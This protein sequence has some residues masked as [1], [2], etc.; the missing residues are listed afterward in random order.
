MSTQ[1]RASVS[2]RQQSQP[3]TFKLSAKAL[4]ALPVR[5]FALPAASWFSHRSTVSPLQPPSRD[6]EITPVFSV[7]LEDVLNRQ[8]LPPLGL[9]DFE[10]WLLYVEKCPENL[11]F[12]LWL[13]EYTTKYNQWSSAYK[14]RRPSISPSSTA[15]RVAFP[16]AESSASLAL[17]YTRAKQTFFTPKSPYEL[18]ISSDILSP[19]HTSNF[20]SP[21]PDPA[22]FAEVAVETQHR[23]KESLERMVVAAYTNVGNDRALCGMIGGTGIMLLGSIPPLLVAFLDGRSR[24]LRLLAIPGLWIGLTVVLASLHGVCMMV[25]VFGDLRQLRK[26]ELSRPPISR[27]QPLINPRLRPPT[28]SSYTAPEP[29]VLPVAQPPISPPPRAL[30]VAIPQ[31]AVLRDP[32]RARSVSASS[33]SSGGSTST[34]SSSGSSSAGQSSTRHALTI[35]I[36]PAYFDEAHLEGPATGYA[37]PPYAHAAYAFP[38]L[39]DARAAGDGADSSVDEFTPTASFIHP[40]DPLCDEDFDAAREMTPAE[41][42]AIGPFDF[43]LL[44]KRGY[45]FPARSRASSDAADAQR[46]GTGVLAGLARAQAAC[47][48]PRAE[49]AASPPSSR[50]VSA[51]DMAA[52]FR[53]VNAV[54]AFASPF[55]RVLNPVVTRAQWEIVVRSALLAGLAC[56]GFVGALLAV[57]ARH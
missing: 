49:K 6:R 37:H 57:P 42:Q 18:K 2:Q 51:R 45:R 9:K 19:F 16:A 33:S 23:L 36:S 4:L 50:P 56:W 48:Q 15:Y 8:H 30:R 35:E 52:Q 31:R 11:Y 54:P 32:P 40:Y 13:K 46:T 17:F 44:P 24:W 26:F 43:D 10:E 12:T 53:R 1:R 29:V 22:V 55:T 21:H 7:K 5:S 34:A 14:A 27:P 41:R 28:L 20:G 3:K 39:H 25:Y 47:N 38:S